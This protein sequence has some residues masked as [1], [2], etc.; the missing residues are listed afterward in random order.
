MAVCPH[1]TSSV[2]NDRRADQTQSHRNQRFHCLWLYASATTPRLQSFSLNPLWREADPV[3]IDR[4]QAT[5][6]HT[7]DQRARKILRRPG[8]YGC[9]LYRA[10]SF[11]EQSHQRYCQSAAASRKWRGDSQDPYLWHECV[12][13][14]AWFV[15]VP[16][17]DL[18]CAA[19]QRSGFAGGDLDFE[20]SR[21]FFNS[22]MGVKRSLPSQFYPRFMQSVYCWQRSASDES[23]ISLVLKRI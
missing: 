9:Q 1:S 19:A 18:L 22:F 16:G 2:T 20:P 15:L 7:Q 12:I 14:G 3:Q 11:A 13:P 8:A 21:R 17:L 6:C 4:L 5:K 23:R 10:G